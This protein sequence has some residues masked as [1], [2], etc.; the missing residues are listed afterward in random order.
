[1]KDLLKKIIKLEEELST[2]FDGLTN[3]QI[4]LAFGEKVSILD[5]D[6]K[7]F[8][9]DEIREQWQSMSLREKYNIVELVSNKTK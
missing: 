8:V 3:E 5:P 7:Q 4:E 2:F 6:K 9:L 1:M